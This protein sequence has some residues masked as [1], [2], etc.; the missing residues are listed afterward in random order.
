MSINAM[1]STA[2]DF[3]GQF[4]RVS[5][6]S[7]R[8]SGSADDLGKIARPAVAAVSSDLTRWPAGRQNRKD[9]QHV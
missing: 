1:I 6:V 4:G 3:D 7:G 2:G 9:L 5:G 8:S